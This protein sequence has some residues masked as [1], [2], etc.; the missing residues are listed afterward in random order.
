MM[1]GS[2]FTV[3]VTGGTNNNYFCM[4]GMMSGRSI[5]IDPWR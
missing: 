1:G 4:G 2:N 3:V 5:Q